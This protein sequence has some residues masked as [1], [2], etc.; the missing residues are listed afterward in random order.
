MRECF[1]CMHVCV[2]HEPW[3]LRGEKDVRAPGTRVTVV[4][5]S[6]CEG[7]ESGSPAGTTNP[8]RP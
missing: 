1:A 6:V 7:L 3:C 2:P 4:G 5:H 8:L